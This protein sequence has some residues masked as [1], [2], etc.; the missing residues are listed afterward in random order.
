MNKFDYNL[1]GPTGEL[2]N[3]SLTPFGVYD[4]TGIL[5]VVEEG[6]CA[7]DQAGNRLPILRFDSI[8]FGGRVSGAN[9]V[10]RFGISDNLLTAS[11]KLSVSEALPWRVWGYHPQTVYK[12]G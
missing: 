1:I 6:D 9:M 2:Q 11:L 3:W 7:Y 8:P 10:F 12:T 5:R 4:A